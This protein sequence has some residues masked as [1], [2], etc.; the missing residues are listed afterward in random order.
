M[1]STQKVCLEKSDKIKDDVLV[2][3][4]LVVNQFQ[5]MELKHSLN[6]DCSWCKRQINYQTELSQGN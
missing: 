2:K 3:G 4:K 5:K 1:G 6:R